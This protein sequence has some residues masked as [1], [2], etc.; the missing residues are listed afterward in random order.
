MRLNA[1]HIIYLSL[2]LWTSLAMAGP[3][4]PTWESLAN[5]YRVPQW[6][7]DGKIG[8]WTHWGVP[9]ATDENRPN[10][11][12][13]YGRRMYGPNAG[14]SGMQLKMTQDLTDFHTKRYG[15]PSE[16][17]YEDLVPLFKAENWD[18]EGLVKFFKANGAASSCRWPATM[19]ISI[20]M[21][22]SIPGM[23][24]I[25]APSVTLSR[26]GRRPP[27]NMV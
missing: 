25:W 21:T 7:V 14:E 1:K 16:F 19:I 12:S 13:H 23:L 18:P 6:F 4:E 10:D 11:G 17:G 20:C 2:I 8:V 15:H 9:S 27:I 3:I 26:S 5:N 22:P 24:W